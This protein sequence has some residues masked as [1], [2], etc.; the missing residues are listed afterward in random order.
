MKN[1]RNFLARREWCCQSSQSYTR[2]DIHLAYEMAILYEKCQKLSCT[3]RNSASRSA[4]HI[5]AVTFISL[6]HFPTN[7]FRASPTNGLRSFRSIFICHNMGLKMGPRVSTWVSFRSGIN[8]RFCFRHRRNAC[9]SRRLSILLKYK[10][11]CWNCQQS[12][13]AKD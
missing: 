13:R 10:N 5:Q 1:A 8:C 12:I 2:S 7:G 3:G 11:V 6:S 9:P 4:N